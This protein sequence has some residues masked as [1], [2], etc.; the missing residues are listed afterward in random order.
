MP[1]ISSQR[2]ITEMPMPSESRYTTSSRMWIGWSSFVFA[3]LQSVCS[4]LMAMA[5]LRL[6]I[7]VTSLVLSAQA[8]VLLDHLHAN[9]LRISMIVLALIGAV[10]NLIT[11]AQIRRLRSRPAAQWRQA[12]LPQKKLRAE[13]LQIALSVATLALIALE[14]CFHLHLFGHL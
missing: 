9:G 1:A 2:S 14:E 4:L 13:R 10:L 6:L 12:P 7:G 3:L 5:G 8:T 11:I